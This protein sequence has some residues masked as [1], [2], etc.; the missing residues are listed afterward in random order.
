MTGHL[1]RYRA[2]ARCR[3]GR[4]RRRCWFVRSCSIPF[5]RFNSGARLGA[6]KRRLDYGERVPLLCVARGRERV[7][8]GDE[9]EAQGGRG[10]DDPASVLNQPEALAPPRS[11]ERRT[12]N[13]GSRRGILGG[14]GINQ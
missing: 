13:N 12:G 8:R 5:V 3:R 1:R 6:S 7:L 4:R 14:G 10:V 11:G 2:P 9:G